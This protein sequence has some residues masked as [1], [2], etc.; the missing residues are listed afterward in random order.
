MR[1]NYEAHPAA[2]EPWAQKIRAWRP[3]RAVD[4]ATYERLFLFPPDAITANT[5]EI[6]AIA[7]PA[8]RLG[9]STCRARR[10]LASSSRAATSA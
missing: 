8:A 7:Q 6:T 3:T 10:C 9:F 2:A 1:H 5:T 4:G